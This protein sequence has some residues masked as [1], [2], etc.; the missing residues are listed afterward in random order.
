MRGSVTVASLHRALIEAIDPGG[1]TSDYYLYHPVR[2]DGGYLHALIKCCRKGC[3]MSPS[4]KGVR[5]FLSCAAALTQVLG[6]NHEPDP[7][8]RDTQLK[9][10][11]E[12]ARCPAC[13]GQCRIFIKSAVFI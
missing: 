5:P 6:I 11:V 12:A 1:P 3:M 8:R 2:A 7:E 10:W 9:R 13:H 4:F